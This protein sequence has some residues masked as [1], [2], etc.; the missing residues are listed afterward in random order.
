[1]RPFAFIYDRSLILAIF[2]LVIVGV[3]TIVY[4]I[5]R[6][7]QSRVSGE[8]STF[9]ILAVILSQPFL[10]ILDRGNIQIIVSGL[11][12]VGFSKLDS[13]NESLSP[14]LLGVAAAMK[15]YPAVFLLI[16]I[17]RREWKR[18][19]I[20]ICTGLTSTFLSL[21]LFAGSFGENFREMFTKVMVFREGE[22]MWLRYNSSLKALFLSGETSNN[23]LISSTSTF[24]NQNYSA[25]ALT[26]LIVLVGV[27]VC[28]KMEMFDFVILG[29]LFCSLFIELTAAYVLTLFSL[30]FLY[31][32]KL[33]T[34]NRLRKF[35]LTMVA[36]IM[37]PKGI[38]VDS[39]FSDHGPSLTS[40]LNPLAMLALYCVIVA[41][42][43]RKTL[44][45]RTDDTTSSGIS[46]S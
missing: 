32:D 42:C 46:T 21:F 23:N 39:N 29:A 43:L 45:S 12:I 11:V 20:S 2:A 35:E 38:S 34:F 41:S 33:E 5:W 37:I 4:P 7:L 9:V 6:S 15:A 25:I 24:L 1:M 3:L 19:A 30:A 8:N 40:I 14:V 36:I 13:K 16:F 28:L 26:L 18:L 44:Q 27:I 31:L 17:R 22:T 10:S